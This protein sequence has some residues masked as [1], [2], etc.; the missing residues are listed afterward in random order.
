[1]ILTALERVAIW[2]EAMPMYHHFTDD[3]NFTPDPNFSPNKLVLGQPK[4]PG[5]F[6][7]PEGDAWSESKSLGIGQRPYQADFWSDDDLLKNKAVYHDKGT[8]NP[9]EYFVPASQYDQ[10]QPRGVHPREGH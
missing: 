10:L 7:A 3:P 1:M 9:L 2:H 5:V 6:L 4:G 8:K